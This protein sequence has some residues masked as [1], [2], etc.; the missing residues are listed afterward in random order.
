MLWP[1]G[2]MDEDAT[3]YEVGLSPDDI[4]LDGDPAPPQ[5]KGT[6]PNFR[7]ISYLLLPNGCMYQDT[8]CYRGWPQ[9]RRNCVRWGPSCASPKGTQHQFSANVRCGQTAGWTKMPLTVEVGLG[10]G[11]FVF[12]G[13][14]APQTKGRPTPSLFHPAVWPQ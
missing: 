11:D 4:V 8:S 10:P 6:A 1:N 12:G 7:S 14:P 5:T 13:D 3:W 9:P 2:W